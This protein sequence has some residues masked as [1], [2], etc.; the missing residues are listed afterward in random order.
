MM[1]PDIELKLQAWLD[2]ELPEREAA[3]MA[4]LVARDPEARALF[5]QL[6]SIRLVLVENEP[7]YRLPESREFHWTKIE[8]A[9]RLQQPDVA[10]PFPVFAVLWSRLRRALIPL[11]GV[12]ALALVLFISIN[13]SAN[14]GSGLSSPS[15]LS[16]IEMASDSLGAVTFRSYSDNL[17]VVW[18]YNR[19]H[20]SFT[21]PAGAGNFKPQ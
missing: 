6:K 3:R 9:I 2:G 16:E 19:E 5:N 17:T 14:L 18:F 12:A 15:E 1:N 10:A 13:H 4:G 8:R 11:G 21:T 7:E 20:S